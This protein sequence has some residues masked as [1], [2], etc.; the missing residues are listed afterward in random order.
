VQNT[1]AKTKSRVQ[2]IVHDICLG[3]TYAP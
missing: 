2:L 1:E 3:L